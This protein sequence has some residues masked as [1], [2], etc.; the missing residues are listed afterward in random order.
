[1]AWGLPVASTEEANL[2]LRRAITD[3]A[4]AYGLLEPGEA[5]G[6]LVVVAYVYPGDGAD[7]AR[8]RYITLL[9]QDHIPDHVMRGLLEQAIVHMD[10]FDG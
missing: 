7:E 2:A 6:D 1:M 4:E 5:V 9:A 8:S 3:A 10:Y